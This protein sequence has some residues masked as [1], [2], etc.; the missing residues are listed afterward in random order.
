MVLFPGTFRAGLVQ[1]PRLRA[2][3]PVAVG[4]GFFGACFFFL[5]FVEWPRAAVRRWGRD[6]VEHRQFQQQAWRGL[7]VSH[8]RGTKCL[9]HNYT[10]GSIQTLRMHLEKSLLTDRRK[11]GSSS[12]RCPR[13]AAQRLE[14][15]ALGCL[16]CSA[17][18]FQRVHSLRALVVSTGK[19]TALP[20]VLLIWAPT[21]LDTV[22]I[23]KAPI[24]ANAVNASSFSCAPAARLA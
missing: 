10:K 18:R 12:A 14:C 22:R 24:Q 15:C 19:L 5:F 21:T 6:A 13:C 17:P 20:H 16:S 2:R 7:G 3:H 4:G 9:L 11:R 1:R 8:R 23:R